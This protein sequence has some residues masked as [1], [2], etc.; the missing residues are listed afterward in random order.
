MTELA[1]TRV[2]SVTMYYHFAFLAISIALLG[3]SAS[4]VYTYVARPWLDRFSTGTLLSAHGMVFAVLTALAMVVLVRLRVGLNYSLPNIALMCLLY[5]VAALPFFAGGSVIS[6]AI[7][8]APRRVTALY[9]ADLVGASTGCLALLPLLNLLGAP[10]GVLVAGIFGAI[11]AVLA[12]PRE[13]R[14][15]AIV[16][17]V[18]VVSVSVVP[19]VTGHS[20]V[21]LGATKGHAGDRVLFE[22]WNSFSRV[23]VYDRGHH[24]WSLSP[25]YAG[26][27]PE[28]RYMD[29]DSAAST[30]IMKVAPDLSGATYLEYDLTAF[31]YRLMGATAQDRA[32]GMIPSPFSALV[33]GPGGG[34]DLLAALVHGASHVDGVEINP[35]IVRDVML[36]RFRDYSG[37]IYTNPRVTL[38]VD[39]GRSHV[40]KTASRYDIIQASL[41]DTWAATAAGAYA[42]TENM[43]YTVE[44]F[45]DYL[46]HL[47]DN[48]VLTISRWRFDGLRL[49]SLAQE[50]CARRGWNAAG[51]IAV[52]QHENVVNFMLKRTPF[53]PEETDRLARL[54]DD[55]E[56][57]V[58]YLPGR[59]AAEGSPAMASLD[60]AGVGDFTRLVTTV[61]RQKFYEAYP[62]DVSPATDDRPFFFNTT[63][64]D[65][66]KYVVWVRRHLF[67]WTEP[68][69][70][71]LPE[72][73]AT[74]GLTA[75]F[76]VVGLSAL[77][78]VLFVVGPLLVSR[79]ESLS[80]GWPAWLAYFGCLGAGYMMVEIALLQRFVL[81]LG[82][83]IYS[84]T[85]TL[86][87]LLLG[88]GVGS[89]LS[90]GIRDTNLRSRLFR[91]LVG[92][93]TLGFVAAF[94]VPLVVGYAVGWPLS[95]RIALA[96]MLLFPAGVLMGVPLPT[97]VRL[98]AD[99]QPA[100]VPWAW[101]INGALSVLGSGLAVLVAMTWGFS[102][103][104]LAGASMYAVAGT[105]IAGSGLEVG[106]RRSGTS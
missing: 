41:V 12:A 74:G 8:R 96:G 42:L 97:G 70:Q 99:R 58:V 48:G 11:G 34:R 13:M 40:R 92:L 86:F 72:G 35:I 90:R 19:R 65:R 28:S 63:R 2:F 93:V 30:P 55:L 82:H 76:V 46:D 101:G 80:S 68:W 39:D 31:A 105:L 4:G 103:T 29:I 62:I 5:T 25:R 6:L 67:G 60:R 47:T 102:V 21:A 66:Q 37:S 44:A 52:V 88:T 61:D 91:S 104:V 24:D 10:E 43:L 33:I 14:R 54:A 3:L 27:L 95:A 18:L 23:A 77:L 78:V 49:V 64:L 15:R 71:A 38:Y 59:A 69:R 73:F 81:L 45:E 79:R 32:R 56:F 7:A 1:L 57:R 50:A 75:L 83:P 16:V 20:A 100:L 9:A 36:G 17:L 51:R 53:T 89:W 106:A 87:S 85:V 94:L 98:L 84:L 22:R 26:S